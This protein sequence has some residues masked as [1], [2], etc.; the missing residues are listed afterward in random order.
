[1]YGLFECHLP[2]APRPKDKKR[3][4]EWCTGVTV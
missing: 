1:V 2:S 3:P 4:S